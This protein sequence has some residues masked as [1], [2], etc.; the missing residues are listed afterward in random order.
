M[1]N[2]RKLFLTKTIPDLISE[3]FDMPYIKFIFDK[4]TLKHLKD[5]LDKDDTEEYYKGLKSIEYLFNLYNEEEKDE[6]SIQVHDSN[7]FFD[8]LEELIKEYSKREYRSLVHPYNFIRSI[9][10]RMGVNDINNV[11]EF[12]ERQ[13][14]FL[15][16]DS[17]LTGTNTVCKI[18]E[19]EDLLYIV[20]NNEDW[21]ETNQNITFAIFKEG[22]DIFDTK[23]YSFPAIHYGLSKEN[24]IPTCFIYGIQS[25]H[26]YQDKTIKEKLQQI[27]KRLRNKNVSPEF[28]ISLSLF[29]D[30]LYDHKVK[31]IEIPT[32]QVFNYTYHEHISDST[33]EK[34][35]N[36][37]EE[38]KQ[39]LEKNYEEGKHDDKELEYMHTKKMISRF[40]DKED[41]ISYNKTE[42]LIQTVQELININPEIELVSEPFI[43]GENLVLHINGK[44]NI[45]KDYNKKERT[46]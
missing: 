22:E 18:G 44:T 3:E 38:E 19:Q 14:T 10:L 31:D 2:I 15:K 24:N 12:L 39:E 25:L 5:Y 41:I 1:E 37:S 45:L 29:L 11:E 30:F 7:K 17:L 16:T 8:L 4:E 9:W 42:R 36:Y 32:L 26:E 21:F 28:I 33:K 27:K 23:K 34:Y 40:A 20:K 6:L 46:I 13:L 43:N 35:K